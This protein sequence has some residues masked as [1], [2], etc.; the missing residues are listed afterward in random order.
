MRSSAVIFVLLGGLL[1]AAVIVSAK[2]QSSTAAPIDPLYQE[3]EAGMYFDEIP[4]SIGPELT[5]ELGT[6]GRLTVP[7]RFAEQRIQEVKRVYYLGPGLEDAIVVGL[8]AGVPDGPAQ[9]F[10]MIY[11]GSDHQRVLK[12]ELPLRQYYVGCEMLTLG[13]ETVLAVHGASGAHFHDL[14]LYRFTTGKPELLLAQGS[15]A[16][17]ELR[18]DRA[19]GDPQVWVGIENWDDPAW[20]YATGV[21][22]WSVYTWNGEQ[23]SLSRELSTAPWISAEQRAEGY[24]RVVKEAMQRSERADGQ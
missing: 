4:A 22:R 21:R 2:E 8:H 10:A 5:I 11:G 13:R 3:V 24:V 17:V 19:T 1:G 9:A 23:F 16:G 14:W 6:A 20:S 7:P 15:A 12:A 18:P